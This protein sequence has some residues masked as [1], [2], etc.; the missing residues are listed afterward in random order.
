MKVLFDAYWWARGPVSNRQVLREIV[1]AWRLRFPDDHLILAVRQ[2]DIHS[3]RTDLDGAVEIVALRLWPHGISM[4]LEMPAVIRRLRPSATIA[5]NFTPLAGNAAVFIQDVLFRTNPEWF[6]LL[7]RAYYRLMT[8]SAPLAHVVFTSSESERARISQVV[9]RARAV[10]AVGIAVGHELLRAEPVQMDPRL[11]SGGFWLTVGRLNVRKNV[12]LTTEAALASGR[13]S[14]SFP[15]VIAGVSQGKASGLSRGA[16]EAVADG[17]IILLGHVSPGEL[18]W[19]Y[20]NSSAFIFMTRGEGFGLPP[21]E[22]LAFGTEPIVSDIPV[23]RE[24]LGEHATFVQADGSDLVQL[25]R[26]VRSDDTPAVRARRSEY[27]R[28]H[29]TYQK[30][31]EGMRASLREIMP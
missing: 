8:L 29:Y 5:Q 21:L 30:T 18:A 9:K 16:S 24:V 20:R 17:R 27:G 6:T 11:A 22:A 14:T 23:M 3:A 2:R 15:L 25:L 1:A 19:L 13:L 10:E 26:A 7:E 12:E 4:L 31:V 28:S